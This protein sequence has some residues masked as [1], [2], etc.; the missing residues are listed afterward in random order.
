LILFTASSSVINSDIL[1]SYLTVTR[2]VTIFATV[3]YSVGKARQND[4]QLLSTT[5]HHKD[6][7]LGSGTLTSGVVL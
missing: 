1:S 6:R 7:G 2:V 5:K 4:T 3:Y